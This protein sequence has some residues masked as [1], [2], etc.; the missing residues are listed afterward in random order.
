MVRSPARVRQAQRGASR[1]RAKEEGKKSG[2]GNETGKGRREKTVLTREKGGPASGEGRSAVEM[3]TY[4]FLDRLGVIYERIDHAPAMTM[5]V[6]AEIDRVLDAAI[7]KNLFLANRQQSAFYLL[8]LPGKKIFRTRDLSEQIGSARLSFGTAEKMQE[9]LGVQPGSVSVLGLMHDRGH[10]VRL[11]MDEEW[12][13]AEYFGC[14]PCVNTS[15]LRIRTADLF[16][17][18][19]PATGHVP[20]FVHL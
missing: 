11:L 1:I 7:C 5:E 3:Q 19:L 9:L 17:K 16:G 13:G 4:A 10:A 6:C 14:H 20:T 18:I 15:S 8:M 12:R 2:T